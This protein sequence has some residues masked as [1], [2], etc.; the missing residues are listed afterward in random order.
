MEVKFFTCT[1]N[2]YNE[3]SSKDKG[4]FY[5]TEENL[6]LG[7]LRLANEGDISNALFQITAQGI[8]ILEL[9]D[10]IGKLTNLKTSVKNNLVNAINELYE[11]KE[12]IITLYETTGQNT[13]GAMTQKATTDAI[14]EIQIGG[15][16]YAR[17]TS[18]PATTSGPYSG[19]ND[20]FILYRCYC[21]P[22][23]EENSLVT[24]SF[25]LT[26]KNIV[27]D[28]SDTHKFTVQ[29]KGYPD[30]TT[31]ASDDYA[32]GKGKFIKGQITS[33]IIAGDFIT[34]FYF[35]KTLTKAQITQEYWDVR[36]RIDG[37]SS[38]T[39][40]ISD[41]KFESGN[42]VTAWAPAPED[43][44]ENI[45]KFIK[46]NL[47]VG[48]TNLL[49]NSKTMEGYFKS[50][51]AIKDP[52]LSEDA[53]GF[54]IVSFPE[55]DNLAWRGFNSVPISLSSIMGKTVTFSVEVRSSDY[56]AINANFTNGLNITF[57]LCPFDS[58]TRTKYKTFEL[59]TTPLSDQWKKIALTVDITESFFS[60]GTGVIDD[61]TRMYMQ[62]YDYSLYEMEFR[63]YKL[64]LGDIATDW[65]PAPEDK[66]DKISGSQNQIVT[67]NEQGKAIA[68]DISSVIPQGINVLIGTESPKAKA[69]NSADGYE[70]YDLYFTENKKTLAE[71]GFKPG[72][73][74][75][76]SFDWD[77]SQNNDFDMVY[78]F[79]RL[80]WRSESGFVAL[81]KNPAITFSESNK[82]GR[83]VFIVKLDEKIINANAARFRLDN[84]VL[85]F[86]VSNL[87]LER[88]IVESPLWS[89]APQ[90]IKNKL[91]L[92]GGNMTG[93]INFINYTNGITWNTKNNNT[94]RARTY[95]GSDSWG[96]EALSGDTT[97]AIVS[98]NFENDIATFSGRAS[99]ASKL[100]DARTINNTSFD[101]SSNIRISDC[102]TLDD[103]TQINAVEKYFIFAK[104]NTRG[105]STVNG[106][107]GATILVSGCGN[108]GGT[109]TGTWLIELSAR[110]DKP[111]MTVKTL[112]EKNHRGEVN[113]GYY[114][115]DNN[116]Y[117]GVYTAS[118]RGSISIAI[119]RN[120]NFTIN[121]ILDTETMPTGWTIATPI[122]DEVANGGTGV[123]NLSSGQALIGNGTSPVTTRAIT[124]MT[125]VGPISGYTNNLMTTN[126]LAFWNGAF[127]DKGTSNISKV[128]TIDQGTWHATPIEVKYGGTGSS[129]AEGARTNLG[130]AT[131][132]IS[133]KQPT[134]NTNDLWLQ[135]E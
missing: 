119:L 135:V 105:S 73:N 49:P 83:E 124:N 82:S 39:L 112:L 38:G 27:L 90:D 55:T 75:T 62:A 35:I 6:Y 10:Q 80:E 108:F 100:H 45:A 107:Y 130:I 113:F 96:L 114:A 48:C 33:P 126:T 111:T 69:V 13:D 44:D 51:T 70:L 79:L 95:A 7:D 18:I 65:S 56:E 121:K 41:F 34:K 58:T 104:S 128:R 76:L 85:N 89:P 47:Q 122:A 60:S 12:S 52:V 24:L 117:F 30:G 31:Q 63:K 102:L 40:T 74:V 32:F 66:Q 16:N 26:G 77:I 57:G 99:T 81:I 72:D 53:E 11:R 98:Y 64:E 3:L 88:G 92:S 37:V 118:Y 21:P 78:G 131:I 2:K 125:T 93:N 129:T 109:I 86:T 19:Q 42:K 14:N 71:L 110:G 133:D 101:G 87:K 120:S 127:D 50:G 134:I 106:N 5:L 17:S 25:T 29:G 116:F 68:A 115:D 132:V 22:N 1:E 20:S 67:F 36:A 91:P 54:T 23:A 84:S 94:I 15:T 9:K 43:V 4:S 8:D 28:S 103:K 46:D 61:T 97:R 59:Y 123:T